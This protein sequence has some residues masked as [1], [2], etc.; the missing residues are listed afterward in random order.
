MSW[1]WCIGMFLPVILLRD[2]GWPGFWVFAIP[3]CLG[4][5][6]MGWVLRDPAQSRRLVDRHESACIWFSLITILFHTFF[7]AWIIRRFAGPASGA[8]LA[9][10][11]TFFWILL[12]WPGV[13]KF[14]AAVLVLTVSLIALAIGLYRGDIPYVTQP[15]ALSPTTLPPS[16]ALWLAPVC[17]FG[18]LLCPYLD[19]TFHAARQATA[20]AE[21]RVA[22]TLGFCVLFPLMIL[23]TAAYSGPVV[24]F[25][26]RHLYPQMVFIVALHMIAHSAFTSAA[27]ARQLAGRV[28][29]ISLR[30][31]AI[32]ALALVVAVILGIAPPRFPLNHNLAGGEIV[33]RAFLGFYGLIFPAY[34]WLR[35][36]PGRRSIYR[37]AFAV[38]AAIPMFCLGF[39]QQWTLWLLPGVAI[40]LLAK[41]NFTPRNAS[42]PQKKA[43]G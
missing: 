3:N 41:L 33:Y 8:I 25:L 38:A 11:F 22:F 35:I 30:Q 9:V 5:A 42:F 36:T 28:R 2:L 39:I 12:Q 10:A 18:F 1:T 32:F 16:D 24:L 29:S 34:V 31:F 13:G 21:G 43:N 26:A 19:L 4:A 17:L 40:P 37:V 23:F 7:A 27:H 6:A 20:P 15:L 14:L